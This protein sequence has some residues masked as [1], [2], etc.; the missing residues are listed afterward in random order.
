[1]ELLVI[2]VQD[3]AE[4]MASIAIKVSGIASAILLLLLLVVLCVVLME[5]KPST[6][7]NLKGST[8]STLN[9]NNTLDLSDYSASKKSL[10]V[11]LVSMIEIEIEKNETLD[12]E[13]DD[14][15]VMLICNRVSGT[16][17]SGVSDSMLYLT[18]VDREIIMENQEA[19]LN[20]EW[21]IEYSHD[22]MQ[23]EHSHQNT[24]Y[25]PTDH[26]VR[27]IEPSSVSLHPSIAPH[28]RRELTVKLEE[29]RRRLQVTMGV[30]TVVVVAVSYPYDLAV[31][32]SYVFG[33]T[34]SLVSQMQ[35][36]SQGQ[37][38]IQPHPAYPIVQ[39]SPPQDI[40]A[41]TF[42]DLYAAVLDDV[43]A[44]LG[45]SNNAA[46]TDTTDHLLLMVPDDI[47]R[48]PGELGWG[49]TPGFFAGI[50]HSL[51]PSTMTYVYWEPNIICSW[52]V[53]S[54]TQHFLLRF[55]LSSSCLQ[56]AA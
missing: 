31:L 48:A 9:N 21:F 49:A 18:N 23:A 55:L 16:Y 6:S 32:H 35:D 24:I 19:M 52:F 5:R 20:H 17:N 25:V 7:A 37:L 12:D 30:R 36:C 50:I 51:A 46:I 1:L 42:V 56:D 4:T 40:S 33:P 3:E 53:A 41:Y 13:D 27:T 26:I 10:G 29:R 11:C 15:D 8:L 54:V 43:K 22:W 2:T 44:Q 14:D 45:L 34:N 39:V 47:Q 28:H 38:F